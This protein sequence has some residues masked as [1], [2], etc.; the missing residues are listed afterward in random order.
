MKTNK[1]VTYFDGLGKLFYAIASVDK[2]IEPEETEIINELIEDYW[3]DCD[4]LEGFE[5]RDPAYQIASTFEN[6]CNKGTPSADA[7]KAFEK[8]YKEQKVFFTKSVKY[9]ALLTVEAIAK[10]FGK[11]NKAELG[12]VAKLKLLFKE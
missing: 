9:T 7:Y 1:V 2:K 4:T 12:L 6:L 8:V 3:T 5:V 11:I 10:A